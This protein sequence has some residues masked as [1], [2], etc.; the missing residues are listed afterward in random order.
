MRK[1]LLFALVF[2]CVLAFH[3]ESHAIRLGALEIN[4]F[5]ALTERYTDNVFNT[6]S[7]LKSD[8]STVITPGV[9]I[10]FPRV[11]KKYHLE[12]I[13][14]ADLE[15]F[16]TFKS[17]NANNHKAVGKFEVKFPG[18]LE[19]AVSDEFIRNHDPRGINIGQ[20][21]DFF[22]TNLA[23]ASAAYNLS[24]R[25]KVRLDYSNYLV[26]YEAGRNDFRNRTDNTL[27]GYVYYRLTPKTSAFVEYEYLVIDF[28]TS[29]EFDSKEH[30]LY[31]GITWDVTGKTKGTVKGGYEVKKFQDPS[32]ERFKGFIMELIV[33]HNFTPRHSIKIK[34]IRRTNETNVFGTSF[35][36]TTGASIEYFQKFTGKI[37]GTADISY[38]RDSYHGDFPRRDNTWQTGIG[39]IYQL[40]KWLRTEAKY[41]YTKRDSSE[42]D[43]NYRNNTYY[44]KV[45][46]SL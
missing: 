25:F 12:L 5:L 38:G 39:L 44:L 40:K 14:Q 15:R 28:K 37:T 24:D 36:I 27:A 18:G 10:I 35:F 3:S 2:L 17:E 13:Y 23:S 34:G 43:F 21:L 16:N 29:E 41:S 32:I 45:V 7:D 31:G 26:D 42:H 30:H 11:K 4:P 20:E 6:S 46:A 19:L 8:F 22:R 9:Q 33:D 1:Y